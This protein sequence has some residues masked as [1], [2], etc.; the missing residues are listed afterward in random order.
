[1]DLTRRDALVALGAIPLELGAL[2]RL[3]ALPPSPAPRV[4]AP[5]GFPDKASFPNVRGTYLNAAA[6]HPRPVGAT[7]LAKQTA[8]VLT[9][10]PEGF[11]PSEARVREAFGKLVNAE[12]SEIGFV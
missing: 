2:A 9:G 6:T 11:R 4:S 3:A 12:A 7:D 1:M 8:A 10:S 5:A